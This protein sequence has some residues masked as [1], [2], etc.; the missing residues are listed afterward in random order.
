MDE[1]TTY[2]WLLFGHVLGVVAWVGANIVLQV[3]SIRALRAGGERAVDF[4]ADIAWLGTRYFIPI[5]LT[6]VALGFALVAE[7]DLELSEFWLSAGLAM[8]LVSFITGSAFLGPESG[9]VAG[10]AAERGA[11]DAEVQRRISRVIW[12][13]RIE[14]LL[15]ILTIFVMVVKPGA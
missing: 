8:F 4:I 13:A 11:E 5:A 1:I 14:L 15:L 6:V 3:L 7:L 9:R 10:L 12:V 2:E